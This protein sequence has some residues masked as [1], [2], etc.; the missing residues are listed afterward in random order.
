MTW[1]VLGSCHTFGLQDLG[2]SYEEEFVAATRL[3]WSDLYM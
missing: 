3:H 1:E 2:D